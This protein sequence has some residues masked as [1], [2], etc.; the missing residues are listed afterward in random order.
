MARSSASQESP[1]EKHAFSA[2]VLSVLSEEGNVIST[3]DDF[4]GIDSYTGLPKLPLELLPEMAEDTA[5]RKSVT[6]EPTK[7]KGSP[8]LGAA[9]KEVSLLERLLVFSLIY[10]TCVFYYSFEL[11]GVLAIQNSIVCGICN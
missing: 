11:F 6:F 1:L 7:T 8:S 4:I 5:K 3:E 2:P 9:G 10:V